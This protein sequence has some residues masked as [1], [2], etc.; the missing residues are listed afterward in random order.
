MEQR[1]TMIGRHGAQ[2][3]ALSSGQMR[4][5]FLDQLD[6]VDSPYNSIHQMEFGGRIDPEALRTAI[7][8]IVARHEVLRTHFEVAG[9]DVVSVIDP[10]FA[11]E[12]SVIVLHD[13]PAAQRAARVQAEIAALCHRPFDLGRLPLFR[14]LL[15]R[16]DP[17]RDLL[18]VQLHHIIAD[19]QSSLVLLQ[20]LS[21]LYRIALHTPSSTPSTST[22]SSTVTS[23]SISTSTG[24]ALPRLPVQY[25]DYA[26]WEEA[27]LRSPASDKELSYWLQQL[28]DPPPPLE[29]PAEAPHADSAHAGVIA[30]E[31]PKAMLPALRRLARQE[32]VTPFMCLVAALQ[33]VLHRYTGAQDIIVGSPVAGRARPEFEPLI[34]FFVNTIALRTQMRGDETFRDL[35][36]RV[37]TTCLRAY[38]NQTFPFDRI[39]EALH[40][41][42]RVES[43]PLFQVMLSL[44]RL[45]SASAGPAAWSFKN[46]VTEE[47]RPQFDLLLAFFESDE[48]IAGTLSYRASKF[49]RP[50][51]AR[52]VEHLQE[53]VR[54]VCANAGLS[55]DAVPMLTGDERRRLLHDLNA[56]ASIDASRAC[57]HE[58]FE[59]QAERTPHATALICGARRIAYRE[60]DERAERLAGL[61]RR[62]GVG[63]EVRTGIC[64]TRSPD[65]IVSILAVL[66]AGGAYVPLDPAYP[67]ERL[68][69]MAADAEL[70]VLI[71]DGT[72]PPRVREELRRRGAE[73]VA[74]DD[75][76]AWNVDAAPS[77][78]SASSLPRNVPPAVAQVV[79]RVAPSNL[80]YIIYT[81]GS[82]GMPKGVGIEHR[83]VV[84]FIRWALSV[85][86]PEDLARTL[87]S[88]S[89]C[90]D[91]SI[92]EI[93][94][95]LSCG[96]AVVLVENA[97]QLSAAPGEPAV[98]LINTVPSVAQELLHLGGLPPVRVL[99]LAGEPFTGALLRRLRAAN[100]ATRIFNLY[101][102]SETTTYSSFA[103]AGA[104]DERQAVAIGRPVGNTQCYVLDR[105]MEPVPAGVAGELYIGGH[106]VARGYLNRPE[107]TAARFVPD[108][109]A[110]EAGQRLYRTGDLT[111]YRESGALEFVGRIDQQVKIRGFRI[112]L[113]EID[114]AL[115]TH[116][117]VREALVTAREE[118]DGD[119]RLVAYVVQQHGADAGSLPAGDDAVEAAADALRRFLSGTLPAHMIPSRFVFLERLPLT[120]NGKVDRGRLPAPEVPRAGE[121]ARYVAPRS[122]TERMIADIWSEL[123]GGQRISVDRSF[124]ELG[125]HSLLAARAVLR[126]REQFG[127]EIP[128]R[129]IFEQ[130]DVASLTRELF[131]ARGDAAPQIALRPQPREART[132]G[133]F[134]GCY[135]FPASPGQQRLWFL[136]EFNAQSGAAYHV[137]GGLALEGAVERTHLATALNRVVARHES[138]RT[139]LALVDG[140]LCQIIAPE[141]P[142]AMS[143]T[144]LRRERGDNGD[145]RAR[146]E[147]DESAATRLRMITAEEV[148]R[149]FD[150][151]TGPLVR[152]HLL[153]LAEARYQ[154]LLTAHHIVCDGWS[155][156]VFLDDLLTE[157]GALVDG[158]GDGR[159]LEALPIQYADFA[160][161][162]REWLASGEAATELAHWTETLRGPAPV[163]SLPLDGA[164][165]AVQ[166]FRGGMET[167][168]LAPEVGARLRALGR[169]AGA[170]PFMTLLAAFMVLLHKYSGQQ[171]LWVGT[172]A[173]NRQHRELEH[174]VGFFV[175]TLVMRTMLSP[176]LTFRAALGRVR[177]TVAAAYA[178]Q[179][180]PFEQLVETLQPQRHLGT[181]PLFQVMFAL[182]DSAGLS[183]R[184]TGGVTVTPAALENGTA[185]FDLTLVMADRP[186]GLTARLEYN[187]DLFEPATM[188]R[189]LGHLGGV[190]ETMGQ[191]PDRRLAEVSLLTESERAQLAAWNATAASDPD[192]DG[193]SVCAWIEAQAARDPAAPA[194]VGDGPPV[195]YGA[196]NDRANQLAH[197][198][199]ARGV[200]PDVRVGVC[201]ARSAAL[202]VAQLAILKAGGAYVPLDP[203]YPD[204]RLRYLIADMGGPLVLT[205]ACV[206]ARVEGLAN[207]ARAEDVADITDIADVSGVPGVARPA[208][209]RVLCLDREAAAL[210][211]QP[212][213]DLPRVGS[214][215]HLAYVI[216]TS[217]STG[218][219]KGVMV[220]HRNLQHLVQWHRAAFALTSS[221]RGS[222]IAGLGFDAAAWEVWPYLAAGASL[223]LPPE[224]ARHDAAHLQHWLVASAVSVAFVPTALAEPLLARPWPDASALRLVLTGGDRLTRR[225]GPLPFTVVN[226][227]GP[228]EATVVA[229]S[230]TVAPDGPPRPSIGRPIAHTRAHV[231]D[232]HGHPVPIGIV[233]TLYL[234]GAGIAR[235]Y[236]H[237]PELT[238]AQFLPD[239]F[240]VEPGQRLYA[241][242]DLAR[243]R[244]TGELEFVG[245]ADQQVKIRGVRIE[246]G[247]IEALL[248]QQPTVLD[249]VVL[250][251]VDADDE[252]Y[253]VAYL[254]TTE[255]R[256]AAAEGT[257][258]R[259]GG[260]A[261]GC[262]SDARD[263]AFDTP[264]LAPGHTRP[265]EPG[266]NG[267]PVTCGRPASAVAAHAA[268]HAAVREALRRSLPEAMVPGTYVRLDRL[269][270][271]AHGK[272]DR[273]AL[274][275]VAR[276][277]VAGV[278]YEAPRT[279]V[280]QQM[281]DI[282]RALLPVER[283]GIRDN[284]FDLGGHS[285]QATKVIVRMREALGMPIAI[286][287]LFQHPTIA[288][289]A[290]QLERERERG[291]ALATGAP[292]QIP[293]RPQPREARTDG[294]FAGC[295]VFPASAGQQ[296][297]WFLQEFNAESGAAYHVCG[298][299]ALEGAIEPA[300]LA[301]ALNRVVTRHESL[302]T[303]LA[304]VDGE[305]CQIIA[306]EQP[307]AMS[308]T[309]L[310]SDRGDNGDSSDGSDNGDGHRHRHG[311]G[312]ASDEHDE[313]A[314]TRL[315]TITDAEAARPF[316]LRTG[317]LVRAQLL[318]L[319]EARYQL[320]FTA[321]H[322]VCDGW[323]VN[324]FLDDLLQQYRGLVDG[325][326]DG[327]ALQALPIQYADFAVWQQEWLASDA[328]AAD[329]TYWTE[330]LRGPAPA[331]QLPLDGA[332]P[333]VQ[334]FRGGTE[335]LA[336][337]PEVGAR[338]RALGRD[339]GATPFMTLL[340]AFMVLLHKY[341][342]QQDLWVG[343]PV[344]NRQ[345]RE[346]DDVV[347]FFVNTLVMRTMF[348]PAL[349]VRA[350][351][352]RVRA[353]V[354][355]AYE[356]QQLPF[357]QLVETLQPQR[358]LGTTPLFQVMFAQEDSVSLTARTSGGVT[359]T[360]VTEENGTAKFDLTLVMADRPEGLVA[361]L[362]YNR[363]LFEAP[364]I[365]RMLDHLGVLLEAMGQAPDRRLAEVSLL[366]EAERA[367]LAAWNATAAS[368]PDALP[369]AESF[370]ESPLDA[371]REAGLQ[372]SNGVLR[373]APVHAWVE[374]QAARDPAAPAIV[375]DGPPVSYGALNDRANQLAHALRAQG[376][377]PDV[378]VGV[379]LARSAALIVAQL[380]ILKAGGA[381]VPLDPAYPDERLRY[382]IAD[383]GGPLV[384]THACVVARV[385]GLANGARGEDVG[386]IADVTSVPDVARPAAVQVLCLDREAALLAA[387][388]TTNL[389][390]VETADHLAY[391]IYT[392]GSTG[393]PKGVMVS[394]RNLQHLVQWHR[395]AFAL[396]SSDRGSV[397]A[398]LGFDAAAWEVWPYLATGASLAL[399]PEDARHD[400]AHLQR[401]LVASGVSVA[402]VPTALAEPLLAR[403]WPDASALRLVLTGGDRLTRRPG[404]LPFT[405]VNNYGPTEATV[406]ATSGP[407]TPDGPPRPSIGRAIAHTRAHVLDAHGQP[408]PIGIVG[409]LYLGGAGIARGYLHRPELTAAQ[410]LPDPFAVEP[411]QR[412]YAT[413][414][415]VRYR[416]SGELE[417]I[418]RADQQVKIRG[419]RIELGE[420]EALLRQQPTVL[421]AVVLAQ[422]EADA[423]DEPY[424]VAYVVT[425][426]EIA[427]AADVTTRNDVRD[428]DARAGSARD[429][430]PDTPAP[431][432]EPV[433]VVPA[434][435]EDQA[436]WRE[437]LRRSLPEA[438]VPGTYVRLDRLP[439]TAHGKVDR[440]A[441]PRVARTAVAGVAYEAPRTRVEQQMADIW[442]ALL[443]VERVGIRDNF[444]DLGGHSLQATKVIVRMREALGMPIAIS[445]LFQHP[446]IAAL[447]EQ[448]E[449][450]R[451]A[452]PASDASPPIPLRS[453]PREARTDGEFAGC[454]VFPA[455][456]GQ[457]RL[458]FLQELDEESGAAYHVCG[459][460]A[461]EGAVAPAHMATALERV[462]ARHES[463]RTRLAQ[464]D[465]ELCQII[466][467]Y[468]PLEMAYVDL[469]D[470][471]ADA[472]D[473]GDGHTDGDRRE[474]DERVAARLRTITAAEAARPFELRTGPLVRAQL[475][476]LAEAR[477]QL[478]FTA[479]HIVCDGWSV[480][481]FLDDLLDA[482]RA[483]VN[484][485]VS[486]NISSDD[487][488]A[489]A[490][491]GDGESRKALPM[492]Y[493]DFTVW[494][495]DW[496]ASDAAA[497]DLAYWTGTL[498]GPAPVLQLPF[499]GARPA[500]QTFGGGTDTILLA[501]AVAARLRALGREAGATPY[502]TLLAAFTVLL[503]KYS[504]QQDLWIGTPVA[505]RQHRE[506]DHAVGF[507]V[508][509]LVMRT[510]LEPALTVREALARVRATVVGAYEH[511]QLPFER[512]VEALQPQRHLGTTPLFQ[513]MFMLEEA[514]G[515]QTRRSAGLTVTPVTVE[516][517]TAKFDLT[518][519]MA[520]RPEGLVARLDY[521]RDLF[522]APT[523]RRMLDHLGVL[524]DA[525]GQAPDR[526]LADI[527]LLSG[528]EQRQ[529]EDW[530]AT[531]EQYPQGCL[532]E[533]FEHR[534][535]ESPEAI[536]IIHGTRAWSYGELNRRANQ[537]AHY[538]RQHGVGP[539][540]RVGICM[541]R[542]LELVATL[543]G[544]LKA[545]GAYVPLDPC[546]PRERLAW[547]LQDAGVAVLLRDQG[548]QEPGSWSATPS[549]CLDQERAEI[550]RQS[551]RN[552]IARTD[553]Q[554]LAYVIYTSG[555]TGR[556]KGVAIAHHSANLL[557]HWA[558]GLF[559]DDELSGVLAST[560]IC[561][562]LS[563]FELFVPLSWGGRIL[564]AGTALELAGMAGAE[565]VRLINTVPSAMTELLRLNAI[566][567]SV[568]TVN[569]AGE[570]LSRSL[571]ERVHALGH[572]E[573]LFN[574]YG[575]SEDTTY[576]TV[577]CVQSGASRE[578]VSI[579][580]PIANTSAYVLDAALAP[581]PVGIVGELYLGGEG[582]ARGYLNRP[583]LTAERFLPDPYSRRAGRR[584]YRT[585]DLVRRTADGALEFL[586]RRDH[587]VKIRGY[588]I[589]LG[590]IERHL[591]EQDGIAQAVVAVHA[592]GADQ[593]LVAYVVAQEAAAPLDLAARRDALRARMPAYMLPE[594]IVQ[595]AALP[596]TVNG[597]VDRA[598]LP[599]PARDRDSGAAYRAPRSAEEEI[600]CGMFADVL[601][602]A[603]VGVD[604][605]FFE[606]GGHSLLA[607][608]VVSRIR[609]AFGV[610]LPLGHMFDAPTP[611][612]VAARV[613][614][615]RETSLDD[616]PPL[617]ARAPG[618]APPL[619]Y[620]QQRLWFI[621]RLDPGNPAYNIG[622]GLRLRGL[623]DRAA[624]RQSVD[625]LVARH[626][627]LRTS[628]PLRAPFPLREE[629]PVQEIAAP[630]AFAI[631]IDDVDLTA[632]PEE[633]RQARVV[634]EARA[635][636]MRPFD[637]ERGPL[638]RVTLLRAG[639]QDH[640]LLVTLHHI[641]GDG[642]SVGVVM[643]EFMA[644]YRAAL[645]N[646]PSPLP[647]LTLQYADYAVWQRERVRG[648]VLE[649]E[650]AWWRE[651]L[652]DVPALELP[653]DHP[654]PAVMSHRGGSVPVALSPALTEGLTR[655]SHRQGV[656]LFMTVLAA[657]QLVLGRYAGQED[658]AVGTGIANRHQPDTEG[659]VG[660]FVNTLVLRT[661]LQ[662]NPTFIELLQRVRQVTLDAY[663]HQDVPFEKLVEGLQPARDLSRTPLFQAMLMFQNLSLPAWELPGLEVTELTPDSE[664]AKF[665]VMLT[666]Q[667]SGGTLNGE[668]SY[669]RDLYEPATMQR[670]VAHLTEVLAQLVARPEARI[671]EVSLLTAAERREI[672][673]TWNATARTYPQRGQ[674][675]E[676]I[677]QQ[678]ERSPEAL[679]LIADVR[680]L[681]YREVNARANQLAGHLRA[682]GVG[683]DVRVGVC[684]DRSV[685]MVV[686]LLAVLKA[687]GA[688]LPLEPS[689]PADRLRHMV[690]DSHPALVLTQAH[691]QPR[692]AEIADVALFCLDRDWPAIADRPSA[693]L[694]R[695]GEPDDLAYVIYTSGSTGQ[696]KGAMNT[697]R[698]IVNRLLWMQEAYQLTGADRVLQKTPFS[699]DVSVWEFFWPL[700]AGAGLVICEPGR[701]GDSRYLVDLIERERVTTL[702]F[703]PSMLSHF[704]QEPEL[705]RCASLR[706]VICSGEALPGALQARFFA[707]MPAAELHNLYG[708]TE[709]SVDVTF[710][711]CRREDEDRAVPIGRPIANTQVYVLDAQLNPVPVGV[712]GDLY[713]GGVGLARG[714]QQ[715]PALTAEKFI[716]DP[717]SAAGGQRLY[718][719]GDLARFRGDGSVEFLG[720]RD[721]QVKVRG[722]RI[723]LGEIEGALQSHPG[724]RDAVVIA[725]A[726][727]GG[728]ARL[729]AYLVSSPN[730]DAPGIE[731]LRDYLQARLPSY[732]T[733]AQ[734]IVLPEM[735]LSKNGK[736]DRR[737]LPEPGGARPEIAQP[738]VEASSAEE[739]LLAAVWRQ[740]LGVERVGVHDNFFTLGG[741]SIRSLQVITQARAQGLQIALPQLFQTPTVHGLAA[742]AQWA[743]APS[744]PAAPH[745]PFGLIS[746]DDRAKLQARL[747]RTR[748]PPLVDVVR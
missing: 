67:A 47:Q 640:V 265:H 358:H 658:V 556:P 593:R 330:T 285:L 676:L 653:V 138:L 75:E 536:A 312:S 623:L 461:L 271:T 323:S 101:G 698:G 273:A 109:F 476:R 507:F 430:A 389:P 28:K 319:A 131:A 122:A 78:A 85:F 598:R 671:G 308:F 99:N 380:A 91:L 616:A 563:I 347:G 290:E 46:L 253:L 98:S 164:R 182:E 288:A 97:L 635:G 199:R 186:E 746:D 726:D 451:A 108:P 534:V 154:L 2:G 526:R 16:V 7:D 370:D 56:T 537:I 177:A 501:P 144:D 748:E 704:L 400:A 6:P 580:R 694:P 176:S 413:G 539:D 636:A 602:L 499:D 150:L 443:P 110:R 196:L 175:N 185:K 605:D 302:R 395:T 548:L 143:F 322:I 427:A 700:L 426:G 522:E 420:I 673:E 127:L 374:A 609:G 713:I 297:L 373:Q 590:E 269:P 299:L 437:A 575:P 493:A 142:L 722:F 365:R 572:V 371:G 20:E 567:S 94:A 25:A 588:R 740:V 354:V 584:M 719:T 731:A 639:E 80:A 464:I 505:N 494:Q 260:D 339:A 237:R 412:L 223:A 277:A 649:R 519:I 335:T 3:A 166:T 59:A 136:Q 506:L 93:F 168:V 718:A 684:A 725:R 193:Q 57:L 305:L 30:F 249:A 316:D 421:D 601:R 399:P 570:A 703:V 646:V 42:R 362:D 203:A 256:A 38:G 680:R 527:S 608:Q 474:H 667:E 238:A 135:V 54:Q 662:G 212:T 739:Q 544:V 391:V 350:A 71:A 23:P 488:S 555:S 95:P 504:G 431:P 74:I 418:G 452:A 328:A 298:G 502:M 225:P 33:C 569:L 239:P 222:V 326:G 383:M 428:A 115:R 278:A 393:R 341:S 236:L 478:L 542:G 334:T 709:A 180:L 73:I 641:I 597:K 169:D 495:R 592:H 573:R 220:S 686:G 292:P 163:L 192:A 466:A 677:E 198:L 64:V 697:H 471:R 178:H 444:F 679:A 583:E 683:P 27:W 12:L 509:T 579:G 15:V 151:R 642:W 140:E 232:A 217:G 346:L 118:G 224:D 165:P 433:S 252:P 611:A 472:S 231:L 481:V 595:L 707:A 708:P 560:S 87:A 627:S 284:F 477:Y 55:I 392:S 37:R 107:L 152:A 82:T 266:L 126:M 213:T 518:L 657:L 678:V 310:R 218:R 398:G 614:A 470:D 747:S 568:R 146:D 591:L 40:P 234:G 729:V 447:A 439:V 360:P 35:L 396:T 540:V 716:P 304:L 188:Q 425:T 368:E 286:S 607:T 267:D 419:V 125:G 670:L 599:E 547:M 81:S 381:Y 216:Y 161:W 139:R 102:P 90:F 366:T 606:M 689:Y 214:A 211:A 191:A 456:A 532:H 357:E 183:M 141:Q 245:R 10:P 385:E 92:F 89:I 293:L 634:A 153:R 29:L 361:R 458:W 321:H 577:A 162:Q 130:P 282:W 628:F 275:R 336:L 448:L 735:P 742:H 123:L 156:N 596:L 612:R 511:Q 732:M 359:V 116:P 559:S 205:H 382:L 48:E 490:S 554:H 423:D 184:T 257:T 576:S 434:T 629:H 524:L 610:R 63:P 134:A 720:R 53:F 637:L 289:L 516:H 402:F 565:Q 422:V 411:G 652:V 96:G 406:V 113:G 408:V 630:D 355:G 701:H 562:D 104:D 230:G 668:L 442:R 49:R 349:T 268:D 329:L 39:V 343:T 738:Y 508:N 491:D 270:V 114:A 617:A 659:I 208:G 647:P 681:S 274:P 710:W 550:E 233:G 711:K 631:A 345:H 459:S 62:L 405:V 538:L 672:V 712:S 545:G 435:P 60:V 333:A 157:Y 429:A 72:I 468:Q 644:L 294:E 510:M 496:L 202:I 727:H 517:D 276:S 650:L 315:R 320:L 682:C 401:W 645:K 424:L 170:T 251:Q 531:D 340:A 460:L 520:D 369:A 200:G 705:P 706:Q 587:Q 155:V 618:D 201:L 695:L 189:M 529:L 514:A 26:R 654:R 242:G 734:F 121:S 348:E 296:R 489:S 207:G 633:E 344:A 651:R 485:D 160:A 41:D 455:S 171:D 50:A 4:L 441:L 280:E 338:L 394:H 386:D 622:A 17:D 281:A 105:R 261:D 77:P 327:R 446:T 258:R 342:G 215:D 254:V 313:R 638:L 377:G 378:R 52:L 22:S 574:L 353:T 43:T 482:Y 226:N 594:A 250:A 307:L 585:G 318:R 543:L 717:F 465:G 600:L 467:P 655:V 410:F 564:L 279:R 656:T 528:A 463:L 549:I 283:V 227:Y 83:Q 240:A 79:P 723:E 117:S 484:G 533:L 148:A 84:S 174:A 643:R 390:R 36:A 241:T 5:W 403:P 1:T 291:E 19:G 324:V 206:V 487:E 129:L 521:N 457:Q 18:L 331:L 58:L 45:P 445:A 541:R 498:Q 660:F 558:R 337:T 715:R 450:E 486:S 190:L 664:A 132:D 21:A 311:A 243:Y 219:P 578:A 388:P 181:T 566:P 721:F 454:Y 128:L 314:A 246:L 724:I 244:A 546:Y 8:R 172:P 376:V 13:L 581:M 120:P 88:T 648:D 300:H 661:S 124:F 332:R 692:L 229:T 228:T 604:D 187:R 263:A 24:A 356:H 159:A 733:P 736:V 387:Q 204:E 414:D 693:N 728:E 372:V 675:Q 44:N 179:Q 440:A 173:A 551:D 626:D 147:D 167:L 133:E 473:G 248:R 363:D 666:L 745:R 119:T 469:R 32:K 259:E 112:E 730:A 480:G 262:A 619:S 51:M 384:L 625:A 615:A 744:A 66:K 197:A 209:V 31:W 462:A 714:Y 436:A 65:M 264:A 582:Q 106:G 303:R 674:L 500:A 632:L 111:R 589:E 687:G 404:P 663:E 497:A 70:K 221:D 61:L 699:F 688:Y 379:C 100:V 737:A 76:P 103:C 741:D 449:R 86:S 272:V 513:V 696:P 210:A 512:L 417:F 409:T 14:T 603:S 364:T 535:S 691:L 432:R 309:D 295:Y 515:V 149:P 624:L 145:G 375:G 523:I 586:G 34:G 306:P 557:M 397:I 561:F 317:P 11:V 552:Q 235:G 613:M 685:E 287:A 407:V 503:H 301:T 255:E 525:M 351:L 571:V 475:L 483:L 665:E 352:A 69:F 438:M 195:S 492:Q 690:E 453:Q 415:L 247:E 194:I 702:H 367:Q 137:C 553:V 621:D 743:A 158:E 68:A 479:H 530:N 416:A 9:D 620:G 325:D 669:A